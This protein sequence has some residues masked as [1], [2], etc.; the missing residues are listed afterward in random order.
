MTYSTLRVSS[1]GVELVERKE[2]GDE[3]IGERFS[4][5]IETREETAL[6]VVEGCKLSDRSEVEWQRHVKGSATVD[7]KEE[8]SLACSETL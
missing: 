1:D 7:I 2:E 4:R 6:A 5:E 3:L 8:S